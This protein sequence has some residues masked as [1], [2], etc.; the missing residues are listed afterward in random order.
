MQELLKEQIRKSFFPQITDFKSDYLEYK[1]AKEWWSLPGMIFVFFH[2]T[3]T[4]WT[5]YG[6]YVMAVLLLSGLTVYSYRWHFIA[7]LAFGWILYK[8]VKMG[9]NIISML[10]VK[11]TLY[12]M[13]LQEDK[14]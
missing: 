10:K 2:P 6:S 9:W 3:G 4:K 12:E 7:A 14:E 13:F 1:E 11:P 5:V 8:V